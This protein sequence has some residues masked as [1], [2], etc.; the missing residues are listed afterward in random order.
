MESPPPPRAAEL[1]ARIADDL[2]VGIWVA[3]SEAGRFVWANR[4]FDEILGMPPSDE[5]EVG[6]YSATYGIRTHAGDPYPEDRMPFVQALTLGRPVV[7]DDIAI[8]RRDGRRV[9]VRAVAKPLTDDDGHIAHVAVVFIDI[10]REV[11]AGRAASEARERLRQVVSAAP[12]VLFA[13]DRNLVYTLMDGSGVAVSGRTAEEFTGRHVTEAFPGQDEMGR[14]YERV[15]RGESITR[16]VKVGPATFESRIT[17]LRDASGA[18]V[19]G[20]GVSI[21]VTSRYR[22]QERLLQAERMASLG[23]LSACIA[24]EI[25]NPLFAA[26]ASLELLAQRLGPLEPEARDLLRNAQDAVGRVQGIARGL[27]TFS[28]TGDRPGESSDL[29][30]VLE[31]AVGLAWNQLR[32]RARLTRR[33]GAPTRVRG[34]EGRLAQVFLNLLVNAAD[35]IPEGAVDRNE[36]VLATSLRA[37]SVAVEVRDT[38]AGIAAEQLERIFEPFF[39]TKPVGVGSGLGLP[40]CR[41][42]VVSVGGT[43]QVES[44]IGVGTTV[45]VVLPLAAPLPAPEEPAAPPTPVIATRRARILLLDDDPMIR[46]LVTRLLSVEHDVRVFDD[47]RRAVAAIEDGERFDVIVCDVMMPELSGMDVH[48]RLAAIAPDQA[49]RMLF[50][51][52]GAFTQRARTFLAS[53]KNPKL[54]KPFTSRA[55]H[56]AIAELMARS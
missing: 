8:H 34:N 1:I 42:I 30:Q 6:E 18:I 24:H 29:N 33:L 48:E 27:K 3:E 2:P 38:G 54:D 53:V 17:P 45:R 52:G 46:D 32:H 14:G 7:V 41:E 56:R 31:S 19:G 28:R 55:L 51:T 47:P 37:G 35:A 43:I 20:I 50:M 44:T 23:T 5:P 25:N 39:T 40:I 21:D 49:E 11:E 9:Y 10:T 4:A 36:V 26:S 13:F 16:E 22:M 15:L 12:I